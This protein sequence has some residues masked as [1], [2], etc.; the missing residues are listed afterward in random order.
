MKSDDGGCNLKKINLE[1][2]MISFKNKEIGYKQRTIPFHKGKA[3]I[4]YITQ[5]TDRI[6]LTESVISPL[7]SHCSS[8]EKPINA[9]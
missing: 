4:F 3:V 5:L 8:S 6:M 1:K 9:K 2:L 7:I